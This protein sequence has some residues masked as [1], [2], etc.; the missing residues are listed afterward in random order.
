L[1][2]QKAIVFSL[3]IEQAVFIE[4]G[5]RGLDDC[6]SVV[7]AARLQQESPRLSPPSLQAEV[8]RRCDQTPHITPAASYAKVLDLERVS[9]VPSNNLPA[10][11]RTSCLV[12]PRRPAEDRPSER[13]YGA[14]VAVRSC[15]EA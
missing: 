6:A 7:S 11:R 13:C 8:G 4:W 3:L 15:L 10:S 9:R 14:A 2:S 1:L 5:R 12:E